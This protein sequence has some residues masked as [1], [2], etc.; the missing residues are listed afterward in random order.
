MGISLSERQGGFRDFTSGLK[1]KFLIG[2]VK[3][4]EGLILKQML[5]EITFRI[6]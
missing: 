6:M 1:F 4:M 3:E 2:L 5:E